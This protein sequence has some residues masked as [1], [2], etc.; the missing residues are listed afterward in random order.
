MTSTDRIQRLIVYFSAHEQTSA[1]A[2]AAAAFNI[3]AASTA[4]GWLK[5]SRPL[6]T[7]QLIELVNIYA[8]AM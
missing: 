8:W 2:A 1:A 7:S 5:L 4:R 6:L 3:C